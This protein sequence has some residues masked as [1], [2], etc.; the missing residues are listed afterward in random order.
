[1]MYTTD[2]FNCNVELVKD[3]LVEH[4]KAVFPGEVHYTHIRDLRAQLHAWA[5]EE[6]VQLRINVRPSLTLMKRVHVYLRSQVTN[7]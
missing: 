4:G 3:E 7:S 1:M 2:T 5:A 6:G